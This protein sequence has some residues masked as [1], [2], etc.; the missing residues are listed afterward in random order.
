M[1]ILEILVNDHERLRRAM[2]EV[3][4]CLTEITLRQKLREFISRYE[5][6]ESVEEELLYPA[7]RP[8]AA[9]LPMLAGFEKMHDAIWTELDRMMALLDRA[10]LRDLQQEFFTLASMVESHFA[11]EELSLYPTLQSLADDK[12]LGRLGEQAR[13][14]FERYAVPEP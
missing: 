7:I 2:V 14:K 8:L 9:E 3:R 4:H 12:L 6:H 11:A 13:E 1:N 5:L 10:S